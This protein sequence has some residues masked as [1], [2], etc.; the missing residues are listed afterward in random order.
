MSG[1]LSVG[2]RIQYTPSGKIGTVACDNEDG[3][4]DLV[5]DDDSELDDVPWR[6][7]KFEGDA[8]REPTAPIK[9]HGSSAK[10]LA[11]RDVAMNTMQSCTCPLSQW[12][13]DTLKG[14]HTFDELA[15]MLA[16]PNAPPKK[17]VHRWM[18][19]GLMGGIAGGCSMGTMIYMQSAYQVVLPLVLLPTV[20]CVCCL[21]SRSPMAVLLQTDYCLGAYGASFATAMLLVIMVAAEAM[22]V[23]VAI[24]SLLVL[25]LAAIVA[26]VLCKP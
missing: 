26:L 25:H 7:L 16:R 15:Q 10:E 11:S 9:R 6:D 19:H 21:L 17:L 8:K 3:T 2:A 22:R 14:N 5:F 20:V 12:L 23:S 13:G 18:Y 4:F 1:Q 24:W